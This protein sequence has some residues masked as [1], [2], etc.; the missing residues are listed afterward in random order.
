MSYSKKLKDPRWQKRRL[1][2]LSRDKFTCKLCLTETE[3]LHVHHK[4]Y[5]KGGE[6]WDAPDSALVT[7]CETCHSEE[8]GMSEAISELVDM[9]RDRFTVDETT[10][11]KAVIH[12]FEPEYYGTHYLGAS[13][14]EWARKFI[15]G[16][17][18]E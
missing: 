8:A 2:I 16:H 14:G 6:P 7:L 9:I 12:C 18:D 10:L 15:I 3:T 4:R 5:I 13:P 11:L 1:D 17:L